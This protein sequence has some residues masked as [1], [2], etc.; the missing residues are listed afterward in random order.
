MT[1]SQPN[2]P[3]EIIQQI[4]AIFSTPLSTFDLRQ[5]PWVLGHVCSAWRHIFLSMTIEFWDSISVIFFERGYK[6]PLDIIRFFLERDQEAPFSL[7]V[8]APYNLSQINRRAADHMRRAMKMLAS[9]SMRWKK[10][11]FDLSPHDMLLL[12]GAKDHLPLL[13][14][15]ELSWVPAEGMPDPPYETFHNAP[16]L[17]IVNIKCLGDWKFNL[18]NLKEFSVGSL[19]SGASNFIAT[20]PQMTK[21]ERLGLGCSPD[22]AISLNT[23]IL[24]NLTRLSCHADWLHYL[25]TP[26]LEDLFVNYYEDPNPINIVPTFLHGSS[27]GLKIV[28]LGMA[29]TGAATAVEIIRCTPRITHLHL[30]SIRNIGDVLK[31]LT[32]STNPAQGPLAR[33]LLSF[34][35]YIY[36]ADDDH[37]DLLFAML[38]SRTISTAANNGDCARIQ[39]LDVGGHLYKVSRFAKRKIAALCTERG[40]QYECNDI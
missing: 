36:D 37:M 5:F 16:S 27:C 25:N 1:R 14:E 30:I 7:H 6:H 12:T 13:Q 15:I 31:Q 8:H 2:I 10:A 38:S 33:H 17:N 28:R 39:K 24:P 22:P 40:V 21:L 34:S 9:K 3:P 19:E 20:L 32:I 26:A 23:I 18:L 4:F 11:S 29:S 35:L